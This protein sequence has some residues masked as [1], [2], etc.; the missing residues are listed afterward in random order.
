MNYPQKPYSS[1]QREI[2]VNSRLVASSPLPLDSNP[3]SP[4]GSSSTDTERQLTSIRAAL[5][6]AQQKLSFPEIKAAANEA[7]NNIP[8]PQQK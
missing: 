2:I 5:Q 4:S 1:S 7:I 6:T 8:N 3:S